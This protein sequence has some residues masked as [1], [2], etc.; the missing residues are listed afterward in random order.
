MQT[1]INPV[2]VRI[3]SKNENQV[4]PG[5]ITSNRIEIKNNNNSDIQIDIVLSKF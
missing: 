4:N 2:A 1:V 3:F 5:D